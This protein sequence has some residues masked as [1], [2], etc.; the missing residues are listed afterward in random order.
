MLDGGPSRKL[1]TAE[2]H[3][4][5]RPG[6]IHRQQEEAQQGVQ[7]QPVYANAASRVTTPRQERPKRFM[8]FIVSFAILV[9]L[10]VGGWAVWLAT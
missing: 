7:Q 5:V 2:R 1:R 8:T 6:S 3:A 9:I 10:V 4:A